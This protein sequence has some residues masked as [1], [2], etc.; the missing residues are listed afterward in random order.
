MSSAID[1]RK[2]ILALQD[3][4]QPMEPQGAELELLTKQIVAYGHNYL[5]KVGEIKAYQLGDF[6]ENP[7]LNTPIQE[8]G[9]PLENL[10]SLVSE[11]VDTPGINPASGNHMGYIPGGGIYPTAMGD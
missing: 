3:E 4:T 8:E 10:L 11:H 2:K 6:S 7:L 5:N 9:R 1:L